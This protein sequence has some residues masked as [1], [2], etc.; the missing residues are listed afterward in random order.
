VLRATAKN[1]RRGATNCRASSK[2]WRKELDSERK[3][4]FLSG[5]EYWT[6]GDRACEHGE[7]VLID[8][9]NA[10]QKSCAAC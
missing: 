7:T 6:R 3:D 10:R 4:Y 8:T 1:V 2:R 5:S 9:M